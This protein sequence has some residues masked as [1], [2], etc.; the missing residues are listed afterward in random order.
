MLQSRPRR[1]VGTNA[2]LPVPLLSVAG[3]K[4]IEKRLNL[5]AIQRPRRAPGHGEDILQA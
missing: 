3:W 2:L 1:F 5:E 4:I